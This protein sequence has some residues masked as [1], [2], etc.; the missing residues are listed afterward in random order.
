MLVL[1]S[2]LLLH[3]LRVL[4]APHPHPP[5]R[6]N[7]A[8]LKIYPSTFWKL[9]IT[10]NVSSRNS[11]PTNVSSRNHLPLPTFLIY[12]THIPEADN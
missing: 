3:L 7:S 8:T 5:V 4:F 6:A 2:H 1:S 10:T 12:K 9:N 11:L